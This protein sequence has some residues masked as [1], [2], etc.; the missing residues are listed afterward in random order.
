MAKKNFWC[1]MLVIA[2]VFGMLVVGC[3]DGSSSSG[4]SKP[5]TEG[6]IYVTGVGVMLHYYFSNTPEGIEQA[7]FDNGISYINPPIKN[8]IWTLNP[9]LDINVKNA[10]DS[11][12]VSYSATLYIENG[13][14]YIIVNRKDN[15]SWYGAVYTLS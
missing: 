10:M 14:R 7:A 12:K 9:D 13:T 6:D 2:L 11:R 1:G 3:D 5:Y 15:G 8:A 4:S